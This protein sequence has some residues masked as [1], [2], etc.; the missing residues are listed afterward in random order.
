MPGATDTPFFARA[1]MLDTKIGQSK[2]DDPGD[3]A[4]AG[5]RAMMNGDGDIVTGLHN[6][7]QSALANVTPAAILAE[8]HRKQAE[9]GSAAA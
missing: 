8:Q 3:V 4:E 1:N 5:F 2:K 6:K 7:I 9:P